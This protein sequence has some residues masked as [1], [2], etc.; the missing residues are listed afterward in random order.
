MEIILRE[1]VSTLGKR[2]STI[3][4][5]DGYA[6]NFLLPRGLAVIANDANR[7]QVDVETRQR[8]NREAVERHTAD[9]L[10]QRLEGETITVAV[11]TGPNDRLFGAVTVEDIARALTHAGLLVTKKQVVLEAPIKAL[12]SYEVPLRIHRDVPMTARV[13]VVKA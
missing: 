5:K 4:V 10:R 7:H 8:A 9:E 1:D 3:Q 6:R 12:G 13:R 11:Q 2:G